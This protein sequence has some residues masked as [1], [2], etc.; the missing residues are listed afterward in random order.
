LRS[1][2][3]ARWMIRS[4]MASAKVGSP[5]TEQCHNSGATLT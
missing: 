2:R 5:N 1:I 4:R 3:W